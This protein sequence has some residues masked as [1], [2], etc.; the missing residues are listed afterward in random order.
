MKIRVS[1]VDRLDAVL[2]HEDRRPGVM[3]EVSLK[4]RQLADHVGGDGS[5]ALGGTENVDSRRNE[6]RFDEPPCAG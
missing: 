1:R 4:E 5:M 3:H 2:P 6:Q